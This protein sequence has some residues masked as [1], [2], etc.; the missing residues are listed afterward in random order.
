MTSAL[1]T[2]ILRSVIGRSKRN[3]TSE[4][5]GSGGQGPYYQPARCRSSLRRLRTLR[6]HVF[7]EFHHLI[8]ILDL[9]LLTHL[10][11]SEAWTLPG[12]KSRSSATSTKHATRIHVSSTQA[13]SCFDR[14]G[15]HFVVHTSLFVSFCVPDCAF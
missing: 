5:C 3:E 4:G 12:S 6:P 8:P 15:L 14:C 10:E 2:T 13:A 7:A 1:I 9:A 11:R